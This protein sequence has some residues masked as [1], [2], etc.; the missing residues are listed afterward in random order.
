MQYR[1]IP[2][3]DWKPSS[4]G[5]GAMR[6]PIINGNQA[7]VDIPA[8]TQMIRYAINHGVNY[9]DTAY[10]YHNGYAEQAVAQA[11]KD[12]YREKIKLATK[13]P[14]REVKSRADFDGAF[15][16]Q[17]ERLQTDKIDFY[18]LHGLHRPMWDELRDMGI[19]PWLESKVTDGRVDYLGFSFHDELEYF[20]SIVDAY[21]N[22][23]FCQVHFNYMDVDY[24]AGRR[25]IEYAAGKNLG[26]FIM[27]PLRGGQL[28]QKQP[29]PV[30]KVWENARV[31]RT[32]V[33]WA[34]RWIWSYQEVSMILSGMSTM[35]QV[36]ENVAIAERS[37]N[38]RLNK[39]ELVTV[40]Q[41][42]Q[43]YKD[44][45]PVP[46]TGC[47]YCMP[48]ENSVEIPVIFRIY[49]EMKMYGATP[50]TKM[51]YGGGFWGVTQE[52]NATHCIECGKC[53]E[54]CPQHIEISDWLKKV[55]QELTGLK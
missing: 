10:F 20:K 41:A 38:S 26:V 28:A 16:R 48:C 39:R 7:K 25:G 53:S 43:A 22:W 35:E 40:E 52:Q 42:R 47:R 14:A 5:F 3:I 2:K 49:N 31:Q 36:I 44:L 33:E 11:L 9:L 55:H 29:E 24:Q 50:M 1:K 6:L 54:A 45:Q 23:A 18:L 12:G 30:A 15:E 4:L 34:L 17:L 32:P 13:F 19:I 37:G 21:D 8:A 51:L 27:E 46:C